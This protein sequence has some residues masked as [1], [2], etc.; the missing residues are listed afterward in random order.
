MSLQPLRTMGEKCAGGTAMIRLHITCEGQ[1]EQG[2]VKAVLAPHLAAYGIF[3][4]ARCVLTSKD[5][6]TAKEYR[7][8]LISYSKAKQDIRNWIK[9]DNHPE[10][11]FTTMFDLYALPD[12]FPG[13]AN[14]QRIAD[15]YKKIDALELAMQQDMNEPRFIPYLQLHEFE[16][17]ILADPQSL[18]WEYLEHDQ[19]INRL[20]KMMNGKN[21]ELINDGP[22]TAPSQR[23]VAEI[24]EYDKATAGVSVC[25]KIGLA[26]LRKQCSHFN[27]W[28]HILEQ[29][30]R[31]LES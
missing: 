16:A 12:D 18:D 23:I 8:G 28:V 13:Y 7:G 5:R 27:D 10:C 21:P 6:R 2:F 24:P 22:A 14:A 29:L 31:S 30:N 20:T 15:K 19:P 26:T 25:K 9:E 17:L 3:T 1:T 11:R 4:D